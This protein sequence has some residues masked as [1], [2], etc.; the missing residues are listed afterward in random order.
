MTGALAPRL[1]IV[2][3]ET[4]YDQLM[5]R[6]ATRGQADVF[7]RRR[8]QS[9]D[10]LD[11]AREQVRAA[12]AEIR[13]G[14]PKDWRIAAVRR[15][16][17]DRF[18]FAPED[19]VVAVGQDGL[20]ANVAKYLAG[21]P[22]VG[23]NA[24]PARNPGIL[25]PHRPGDVAAMLPLAAAG[26]LAT[27]KR[28]MVQAELDDGQRLLALNEIFVGHASH[29][30]ARYTIA[31]AGRQE[32]QSSS[33]VIVA[34]GT[35]ATGWALSIS[36]ATGVSIDLRPDDQAA[37]FLAREPWPSRA[38]GVEIASGRIGR[39]DILLL[40]SRMNEGGV[41]FADGMEGDRLDF[42]WGRTL[43]VSVSDRQLCFVPSRNPAAAVVPRPAAV[44]A[45][46]PVRRT[47]AAKPVAANAPAT[48]V[49]AKAAAKPVVAAARRPAWPTAR[50]RLIVFVI[51]LALVGLALSVLAPSAGPPPVG[52]V[53]GPS[54][55]DKPGGADGAGDRGP[56]ATEPPR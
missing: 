50:Q 47:A 19:L 32:A 33:G 25:V 28:T 9:L 2:T 53:T 42:A 29:Q 52:Q 20:V 17:L 7:L 55:P 43:R 1:V 34:T 12:V 5:A 3:R 37:V 15:A 45:A 38:T 31:Y 49:A 24:D 13:A 11:A 27:N 30:S 26:K 48:P 16:E 18:L 6:H 23:V 46:M 41:V 36:R 44:P 54:S 10:G 22:V 39:G 40:V 35:G 21:Q 51:V 4:E 56:A 8:A 14:V